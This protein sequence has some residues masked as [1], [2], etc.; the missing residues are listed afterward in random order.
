MNRCAEAEAAPR[1]LNR[2]AIRPLE[3]APDPTAD[4]A[5]HLTQKRNRL[6]SIHHAA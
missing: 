6:G 2:E 5:A 4:P 1:S 3:Q